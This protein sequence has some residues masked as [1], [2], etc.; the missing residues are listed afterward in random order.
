M[1]HFLETKNLQYYKKNVPVSFI[2]HNENAADSAGNM[3]DLSSSEN[4]ELV[5]CGTREQS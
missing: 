2:I 4:V 5:E 3:S 1:A